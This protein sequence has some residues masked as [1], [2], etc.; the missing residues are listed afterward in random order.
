MKGARDGTVVA[1][2][3]YTGSARNALTD[4]SHELTSRLIEAGSLATMT[5]RR[6]VGAPQKHRGGVL[7]DLVATDQVSP[8]AL[9]R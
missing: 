1:C 8:Q 6:S 9:S 5:A 2:Y 7:V 4:A 3:A